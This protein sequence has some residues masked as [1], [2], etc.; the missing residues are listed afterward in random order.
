[1]V[2][3]Y[4]F[5]YKCVR[6]G[7]FES[8]ANKIRCFTQLNK[9]LDFQMVL[10]FVFCFSA[11]FLFFWC[12]FSS[13]FQR[14]LFRNLIAFKMKNFLIQAVISRR[15]RTWHLLHTFTTEYYSILYVER[16]YLG[17]N[18]RHIIFILKLRCPL[19]CLPDIWCFFH[20]IVYCF[21]IIYFSFLSGDINKLCTG[22][23]QLE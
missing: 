6:S 23:K 5:F 19:I 8:S 4:P 17:W 22:K 18:V 14:G 10:L 1:M 7:E 2:S 20:G 3:L 15:M 11:R 16:V 9:D 12:S 13:L 21:F